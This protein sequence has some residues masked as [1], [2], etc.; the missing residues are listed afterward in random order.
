M[1]RDMRN[2][3]LLLATPIVVVLLLIGAL[4]LIVACGDDDAS[5]DPETT[6]TV[7]ASGIPPSVPPTPI[8][9]QPDGS[10]AEPTAEPTDM[11]SSPLPGPTDPPSAD[12]FDYT[13]PLQLVD[14]QHPLPADYVPPGIIGIGSSYM[15]PG[16][17][18]SMRSEAADAAVQMLDA[19]DADG[20]DIRVRS[21]YRSYE[22]Q[23]V[24]FQ[25]WVSV[26]GYD[27]AVRQSA[28][29]GFS[30]H[31]TGLAVDVSSV[32]V[33]WD[34]IP[35]FGTTAESDWLMEHAGEYGFA[36]SYP[37]CCEATTGYAWE[38]W[39]WRYIGVGAVADFAASG[40][41]LNQYLAQ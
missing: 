31:Q 6:P 21:G 38:P 37:V 23:E 2:T 22:E 20:L 14:K 4:G 18:A 39:H 19:A 5:N 3:P 33:G 41:T 36:L 13:S 29:A 27:E 35:E 9:T 16:F 26:Y 32:E 12:E 10:T 25:Y 40:L 15:A 1:V 11:D 24:T 8:P 30:E 17:S 34:V 28:M 7:T